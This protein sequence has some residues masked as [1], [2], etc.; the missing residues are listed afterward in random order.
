MTDDHSTVARMPPE[1]FEAIAEEFRHV[2][3][4]MAPGKDSPAAAGTDDHADLVLRL[5]LFAAFVSLLG[6]SDG[7]GI[8][9]M[10]QWREGCR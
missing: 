7:V 9:A 10:R 6:P 2:R 1:L 8:L 4:I 3:R 5:Q